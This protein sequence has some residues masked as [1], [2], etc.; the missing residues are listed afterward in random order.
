MA[1]ILFCSLT[2]T[3]NAELISSSVVDS[4]VKN[5]IS[6]ELAYYEQ[7]Q[8]ILG[9]E[10]VTFT[11]LRIS[12][13]I[14][15]Y[16]YLPTGFCQISNAYF[17]LQNDEI[18][19]MAYEVDDLK[20]QFMTM[21]SQ[22][23]AATNEKS[24]AIVYDKNGCFVFNGE[25]FIE[26]YRNNIGSVEGRGNVY[27][28]S[29]TEKIALQ[30]GNIEQSESLQYVQNSLQTRAQ[31][32]YICSVSYVTQNPYENLCWAASTAMIANY[33]NGTSYTA[34]QVATEFFNGNFQDHTAGHGEATTN[35][36]EAPYYLDYENYEYVP[37]SNVLV[38][39]IRNGYPIYALFDDAM[40]ARYHACVMYGIN[41]I[42]GR[43]MIMDPTFGSTTC[44]LDSNGDY[45]YFNSATGA[46]K[47]FRSA[48]CYYWLEN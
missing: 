14:T 29:D 24:F 46:K 30:L 34:V 1:I 27:S 41:T 33:V 6:N 20:Y 26:V 25:S 8:W 3:V 4:E 40:E 43:I 44:Y 18:I 9:I 19:T 12:E 16:E 2:K 13:R 15:V 38:R 32:N 36:N 10:N 47:T 11:N 31:T 42:A 37:S 21:L 45:Y 7:D 23:I 48:S 5:A 17:L 28:A 35:M 39:N 22:F